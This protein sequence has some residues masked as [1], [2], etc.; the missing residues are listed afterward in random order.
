[1]MEALKQ[2]SEAMMAANPDAM[3]GM[4]DLLSNPEALKEKMGEMA[5]LLS[6]EEGKSQMKQWGSQ[7]QELFNDPDKVAASMGELK[8]NPTFSAMMDNLPAEMRQVM[9]DPDMMAKGLEQAKEMFNNIDGDQMSKMMET[10]MGGG[11]ANMIES[12]LGSLG[13]GADDDDAMGALGGGD[14][15]LQERIRKMASMMAGRNKGGEG[16]SIDGID[17]EF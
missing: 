7:M 9:D 2:Q 14:G 15:D 8:N 13:A 11:G 12:L 10:M 17:E 6:S 4:A 16:L 5:Q 1:M 3:K